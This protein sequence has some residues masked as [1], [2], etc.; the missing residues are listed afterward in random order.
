MKIAYMVKKRPD[1]SDQ[2]FVGHWTTTHAGLAVSMPGLLGYAINLPAAGDAADRRPI[3]GYA[4]L[5]F[6]SREQ[7]IEAW[8]SPAGRA[9]AEDGKLFMAEARPFVADSDPTAAWPAG[10]AAKLVLLLTKP[11]AMD[12][13]EFVAAWRACGGRDELLPGVL[14]H[15]VSAPSAEQRGARPVDGYETFRF[16]STDSARAAWDTGRD[17]IRE[18]LEGCAE[19]VRAFFAEER[20][21][22][23]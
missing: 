1:L 21:V 17:A 12:D 13:A 16:A 2:E 22:V 18:R 3:D 8:R 14:D 7:A 6:G 5:R 20:V 19:E 23:A 4:T 11:T 10:Q 15:A 9:T